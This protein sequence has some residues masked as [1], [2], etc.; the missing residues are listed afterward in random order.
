MVKVLSV[1]HIK[2]SVSDYKKSKAFYTRLMKLL[3]FKRFMEGKNYIGWKNQATR[4][5]I[6]QANSKYKKARFHEGM[7]GYHHVSFTVRNRKDVDAVGAFL[8]RNKVEIIDP[9]MEH[10]GG[11]MYATFFR[12][13]DGMKI[14]VMYWG[15]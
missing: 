13:P 4:F 2:I 15:K 10:Y 9:P 6:A 1:D 5:F 7:I 12:D 3:G 8:K 14:E 11:P